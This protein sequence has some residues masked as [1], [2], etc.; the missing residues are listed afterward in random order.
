MF[1]RIMLFSLT[2]IAVIAVLSIV[3][4]IFGIDQALGQ[5]TSG[6]LV[7]TA[8][9]GMGGAFVSL[10]MSKKSAL[11]STGAQVIESPSNA[12]EKWLFETVKKQA[13]QAGIGMPDVAIY[14][15]PDVN[16]FATGMKKNDALVAVSTGL[17]NNMRQNEAEAV[18]AHEISHVANGDMVTLTLIQ[19]VVN[20]F[21]MFFAR[22]I[23]GALSGGRDGRNGMAY[24][25]TV[26]VAQMVLGVFASMIVSW[27]SRYREFRA[28]AGAGELSGKANMVAAL[29]RLQSVHAPADLPEQMAAFGIAGVPSKFSHLF[30]SHPPLEKRI[31]ALQDSGSVSR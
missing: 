9:F 20:T 13:E 27:F 29:E 26:M 2:N 6:L 19:G 1:S 11:R 21:V 30:A 14:D 10:M 22:I 25:A 4:R 3:M 15:S 16:A 5:N 8:I 17:L 12:Q 28:D 31:A 7:M 24:F 18:L 23:A